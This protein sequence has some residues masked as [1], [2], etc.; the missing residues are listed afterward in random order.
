MEDNFLYVMNR[1]L[2]L[3]EVGGNPLRF[4]VPPEEMH[5]FLADCREHWPQALNAS[6]THDTKRG[7]DARARLNVLSEIGPEWEKALRK[8]K[9]AN[10]TKKRVAGGREVP[11]ANTEYFLYQAM[12]GS[13][14]F[15]GA[16]ADDF[17]ARLK[18]YFIKAVREADVRTS[19]LNPNE[20]YET[21]CLA[22]ID[23]LFHIEENPDFW[24]SFR[25]VARRLSFFGVIN[26][27][28]QTLLKLTSPG[29]PDIYQG[30]ELWDFSF[31]DPDNRR[32]V[33]FEQR[34]RYLGEVIHRLSHQRITYLKELLTQ[35]QD[36]RI[37]LFL[38][39]V[40]LW[41][42]HDYRHV[43]TEGEYLS[44]IHI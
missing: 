29:V 26:S 4:G 20:D 7:E 15:E 3:N 27:L 31:V 32:P 36:G 17:Q 39:H 37:K 41:L 23:D 35:Y 43:F 19:W 44:L 28:A 1:L 9:R 6:A 22:F 13:V 42:R 8:W 5:A 16:Q 30:T 10:A 34:Q 11:E 38:L 21:G 12:L 2:S 14:P 18:D 33:D 25:V 24:R 40:V